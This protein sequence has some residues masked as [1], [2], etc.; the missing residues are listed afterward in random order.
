MSTKTK[1]APKKIKKEIKKRLLSKKTAKRAKKPGGELR[2]K[3][4]NFLK[5]FLAKKGKTFAEVLKRG[6]K[7]GL[8]LT[9]LNRAKADVGIYSRK[10]KDGWIW[11]VKKGA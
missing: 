3:A 8:S 11:S 7:Q 5:T 1:K 10:T 9:T 2:V 4:Q 6:K